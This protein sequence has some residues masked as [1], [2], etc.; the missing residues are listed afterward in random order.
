MSED[1]DG[2]R[3]LRS[4]RKM[5]YIQKDEAYAQIK[6]E[7]ADLQQK[8]LKQLDAAFEIKLVELK[9]LEEK[10]QSCSLSLNPLHFFSSIA[11]KSLL[12]LD[13]LKVS[14]FECTSFAYINACEAKPDQLHFVDDY[15]ARVSNT[16]DIVRVYYMCSLD[17][18]P[19]LFKFL[20]VLVKD[21]ANNDISLKH[22]DLGN[23]CYMLEFRA[24]E[25]GS[26]LVSVKVYGQ[27][28][29]GSPV[30]ISIRNGDSVL[31]PELS[32]S[33][34]RGEDSGL[35][36]ELTQS[37]V[38]VTL[39][40]LSQSCVEV[41]LPKLSQSCVRRRMAR[42]GESALDHEEVAQGQEEAFVQ[43]QHFYDT[44]LSII[45]QPE[46]EEEVHT[47]SQPAQMTTV[48]QVT[49][50]EARGACNSKVATVGSPVE[51]TN[52]FKLTS[53]PVPACN[54]E[55]SGRRTFSFSSEATLSVSDEV[56]QEKVIRSPRAKSF[57]KLSGGS[58]TDIQK[59]QSHVIF[60][61][62]N[63]FCFEFSLR[64]A[65]TDEE[66]RDVMSPSLGLCSSSR[67]AEMECS[68]SLAGT[69]SADLVLEFKACSKNDYLN[70]PIGV[71]ATSGGNIIVGDTGNHRV[72]IFNAEGRPLCKATLPGTVRFRR[73]SAVVALDDGSF[74]VKDDRCV[75]LFSK[76]GEYIRTLGKDSLVR[77]FGLAAH[78]GNEL[79]TLSLA[80]PAKLWRFSATG[81]F[82]ASAVY[83]PLQPAAPTGSKCRFLDVHGDFAFVADLGLSHMYKTNMNGEGTSI[84]G[85][86]G[87]E[88]G[89]FCEPS[90]IS[91]S[92][93][94]LFIGDSKN[95]RIQV[96]DFDGNFI[97][98]LKLSSR[99]TR[100]SGIHV[101]DANNKLYVLNY[102]HGVVGVYNLVFKGT[103][104]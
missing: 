54:M 18:D 11:V 86:K 83:S 34:I 57:T 21:A 96:F 59:V 28:I 103:K 71:T 80:T 40:E 10:V 62:L 78:G 2:S 55:L 48:K 69:V 84:F 25:E 20:T 56:A 93:K 79:V 15:S 61:W 44:E 39:P 85:K 92:D 60:P 31:L 67:R 24:C 94:G 88:P 38:E 45:Q 7:V 6:Q 32:R 64:H 26:F 76:A 13:C 81:D 37:R 74:A 98:V 72:I 36:F 87:K 89:A 23:G 12:S 17:Y 102:L 8:L 90:G 9:K 63:S 5:L 66:C 47:H 16:G 1:Y 4:L 30:I 82:E 29:S 65:C 14:D 95:N 104:T 27:N 100:P 50:P 19:V 35:P 101:S 42:K 58:G 3:H 49:L 43:P 33:D 77:P 73:P 53:T 97:N 52:S 75:Y 99:I 41:T 46:A 91:A 68:I 51:S 22:C 70:F